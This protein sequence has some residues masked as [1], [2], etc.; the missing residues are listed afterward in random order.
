MRLPI[1]V[2]GYL[3]ASACVALT[4]AGPG[5]YALPSSPFSSFPPS[6]SCDKS[7]FNSGTS[8]GKSS[9]IVLHTIWGSTEKYTW[10][11]LLRR[12]RIIL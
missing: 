1:V 6:I 8:G 11:S 3:V 12:A 4:I 2:G 10:T 7:P 5:I 9:W